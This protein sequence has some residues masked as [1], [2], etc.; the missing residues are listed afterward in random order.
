MRNRFIAVALAFIGGTFGIHNFYLGRV[1]R[2]LASVFFSF[3]VI[4]WVI[5]I[6][7]GVKMLIMSDE[8]FDLKYNHSSYHRQILDKF[9]SSL[10]NQPHFTGKPQVAQEL[11]KLAILMDKG[12]I[13]FE[14]FEKQKSKLLQ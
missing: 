1:G 13:T 3:T 4:P 2:G 8:E 5:S 11:E 12:L 7:D 14:E 9:G 6:V 10:M